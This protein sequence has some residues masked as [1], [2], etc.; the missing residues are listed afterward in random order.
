MTVSTAL[1][2]RAQKGGA[3]VVGLA[4]DKGEPRMLLSTFLAIEGEPYR[5]AA[6]LPREA[7]AAAVQ[8]IRDRQDRAA[9]EGLRDIL[10]KLDG[11]IV[12]GLLVN[13]AGWITD[14]LSYSL[15]WDEHIPVAEN[16]A[17]REA[18]RFGCRENGI[19][20]TELDEKSQPGIDA[21]LNGLGAGLKP[22][23]KEQKLACVAA[24]T[25]LGQRL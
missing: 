25:A 6:G 18:L 19:D 20:F 2:L 17:L 14:L 24:W 5:T 7:Q 23:R 10:G 12:A 21:R 13:R 22:W 9:A 16:L 15:E 8:E 1:G 3:V 4:I 11:P